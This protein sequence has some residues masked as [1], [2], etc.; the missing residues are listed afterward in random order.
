M[1]TQLLTAE[2]QLPSGKLIY[3]YKARKRVGWWALVRGG[4]LFDET[5]WPQWIPLDDLESAVELC[6]EWLPDRV[7]E[8]PNEAATG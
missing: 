3:L 1:S 5:A 2:T 8:A 6:I 4:G 7:K